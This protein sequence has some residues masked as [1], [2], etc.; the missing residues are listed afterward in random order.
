MVPFVASAVVA[1]AERFVCRCNKM[2]GRHSNSID[3]NKQV[4][5]RQTCLLSVLK[6][7]VS[8]H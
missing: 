7:T 4:I 8:I 2:Y 6:G 3:V 5:F 1:D